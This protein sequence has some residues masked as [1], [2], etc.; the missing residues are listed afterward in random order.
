M[1]FKIF[2]V[3]CAVQHWTRQHVTQ[4]AAVLV[5]LHLSMQHRHAP[6]TDDQ[7]CR[8]GSECRRVTAFVGVSAHHCR[9]RACWHWRRAGR[10]WWGR[11]R[12]RDG[13][14]RA[15]AAGDV[16]LHQT[17]PAQGNQASQQQ[18]RCGPGGC[19]ARS[20]AGGGFPHRDMKLAPQHNTVEAEHTSA[21]D[22]A[23]VFT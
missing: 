8:T 20:T 13:G 9:A 1:E 14:R 16:R 23:K 4:G 11:R 2:T 17:T 18:P 12:G 19:L 6:A 10:C 21:D 22:R 3:L 5:I 15:H 7:N